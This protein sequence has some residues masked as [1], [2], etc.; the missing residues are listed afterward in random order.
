ML[1]TH[2]VL[3]LD[4]CSPELKRSMMELLFN[5][6]LISDFHFERWIQMCIFQESV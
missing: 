3:I 1:R 2:L 6:N 4:D 5:W